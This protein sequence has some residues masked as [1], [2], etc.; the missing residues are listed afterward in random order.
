MMETASARNV[1]FNWTL[2]RLIARE[3]VIAFTRRESFKC[4]ATNKSTILSYSIIL[5]YWK[6]NMNTT[7][8]KSSTYTILSQFHSSP[9]LANCNRKIRLN[10]IAPPPALGS[11]SQTVLNKIAQ[12]HAFLAALIRA[13][14]TTYCNILDFTNQPISA[15]CTKHEV[16]RYAIFPISQFVSPKVG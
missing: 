12:V 11:Q 5:F 13:T 2:T 16:Y 15:V 14:C 7:H 9:I 6:P 4:Y 1:S 3:N 10:V 8:T